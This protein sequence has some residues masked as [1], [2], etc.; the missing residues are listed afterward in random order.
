MA[1]IRRAER[2]AFRGD[3]IYLAGM[4]VFLTVLGIA[5]MFR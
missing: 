5:G 3:W 1:E 2:E 4:V